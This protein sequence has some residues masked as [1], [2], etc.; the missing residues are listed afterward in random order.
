MKLLLLFRFLKDSM[1]FGCDSTPRSS[2]VSVFVCV[3]VH[4]T[5]YNCTGLLKDFQRT[6]DF[7]VYKIYQFT[8]RSSRLV[9]LYDI[10]YSLQVG[11]SRQLRTMMCVSVFP[12]DFFWSQVSSAVLLIFLKE[13]N[14]ELQKKR[15]IKSKS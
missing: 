1:I 13:D 15:K 9:L 11:Y 8:S 4:H 6:L 7:M 12:E 5:C 14:R 10:F 2:N 3:C